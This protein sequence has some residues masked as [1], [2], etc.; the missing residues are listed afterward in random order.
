MPVSNPLDILLAHD[1]WATRNVL[2]ACARLT[3]QQFHQPFEMGPGSLHATLSHIIWGMRLWTD[4]LHQRPVR[5]PE[6]NQRWTVPQMLMRLDASAAELGEAARAKPL[7]ALITRDR[8][9]KTWKHTRGEVVTHITTHA[10][11]HRAQCLNMLRRLGVSP[12]PESSVMEWARAV[13]PIA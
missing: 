7:D 6:D 8:F 4:I 10:V 5:E 11:H 12:L 9:G 1:H 2:D 13:D 3:E